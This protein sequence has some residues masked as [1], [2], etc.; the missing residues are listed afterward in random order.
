MMKGIKEL[1]KALTIDIPPGK[2]Q[3]HNITLAGDSQIEL[4]LMLGD[5][6][7]P[8]VLDEEDLSMEPLALAKGIA[9]DAMVVVGS[10]NSK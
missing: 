1:L 3:R 5:I 7:L 8:I 6:Y 2:G 4:T 9:E 10:M